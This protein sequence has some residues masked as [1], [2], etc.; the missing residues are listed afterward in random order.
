VARTKKAAQSAGEETEARA[1]ELAQEQDNHDSPDA[2]AAAESDLEQF[3]TGA[4][5]EE[6]L[7]TATQEAESYKD[8]FLRA[9]ADLENYRKRSVQFIAE[10]VRDGQKQT[11]EAI[12]PVVDN[13]ERAVAYQEQHQID[14]VEDLLTGVRMTLLQLHDVLERQEV[15]RISAIGEPFDPRFHE[16]VEVQPVEGDVDAD[17]VVGEIQTGYLFGDAVIR[18]ARVRVAQTRQPDQESMETN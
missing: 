11:L 15:K 13:L 18:P 14:T 1:A 7:A 2:G 10:G 8:R 5:L 6:Q 4:S 3:G 12:L 9:R 16:A 17:T